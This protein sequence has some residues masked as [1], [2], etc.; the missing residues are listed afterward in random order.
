M[1]MIPRYTGLTEFFAAGAGRKRQGDAVPPA[2]VEAIRRFG[3][4]ILGFVL[5]DP[6]K[7]TMGYPLLQEDRHRVQQG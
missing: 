6:A 2:A 3:S 1:Y 5:R 7:G 4:M